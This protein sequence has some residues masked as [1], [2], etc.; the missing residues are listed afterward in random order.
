MGINLDKI[1][2][3]NQIYVE[4]DNKG[5]EMKVIDERAIKFL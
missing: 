5:K 3:K 2:F 1:K 4:W